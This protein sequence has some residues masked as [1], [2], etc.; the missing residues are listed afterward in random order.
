MAESATTASHVTIA[1][2]K[3][4]RLQR[5]ISISRID[6][7]LR[8][9]PVLGWTGF[10]S[11][12]VLYAA[13]W[14]IFG[15]EKSQMADL[16]TFLGGAV[17]SIWS[18]AGFA[19]VYAAFLGQRRQLL[20]Q[21]MD[22]DLQRQ[23]LRASRREMHG[24]RKAMEE[25]V[26]T[27]RLQQA[28]VMF[29][30][31]LHHYNRM[32]DSV[33]YNDAVTNN[34]I[35]GRNAIERALTD[36]HEALSSQALSKETARLIVINA[37]SKAPVLGVLIRNL[38]LLMKYADAMTSDSSQEYI[39][40]LIVQLSPSEIELWT[41]TCFSI[42]YGPERKRLT[43]KYGLLRD[44]KFSETWNYITSEFAPSAFSRPA[45]STI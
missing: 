5:D 8:W 20:L 43:E 28:G 33:R 27:A 38:D 18:A 3:H 2:R 9:A 41:V 13:G 14:M 24:Q 42:R 21:E 7:Q 12:F 15:T 19:L 26:T 37:R 23:E 32:V 30:N 6:R 10:I 39:D 45:T 31:L 1:R 25:Q 11:G 44:H 29:F 36:A 34:I 40:A 4:I 17:S 35:Y 22:L 16:G